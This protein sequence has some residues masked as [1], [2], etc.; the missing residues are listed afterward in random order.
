VTVKVLPQYASN[1]MIDPAMFAKRSI[2]GE[3]MDLLEWAIPPD[4]H[5]LPS[6][7]GLPPWLDTLKMV[8]QDWT[9]AIKSEGFKVVARLLSICVSLGMCQA[10]GFRAEIAGIQLFAVTALP[11]QVTSIDLINAVLDTVV[12]FCE[13]GYQCIQQQSFRPLLG[14]MDLEEFDKNYLLCMQYISFAK[15]GNLLKHASMSDNDFDKLLQDTIALGNMLCKTKGSF[16]RGLLDRKLS[17]LNV[18]AS[19]LKQIR[20]SGGLREAPYCVGLHGGSGV[21]KTTMYPSVMTTLLDGNGFASTYDRIVT[22]N[23]SDKYMSS[24]RSDTLGILIDDV[25]NTVPRFAKEAPTQKIIEFMSNQRTYANM[26]EA[27]QKGKIAVE[28]KIVLITTNKKDLNAPAYSNEPAS[29]ARR[30]NIMVTV[31]VLPQYAS[32]NMIDPAKL[33]AAFPQGLPDPPNIWQLT[34]EQAYP[35]QTPSGPASIGYK[36]INWQGKDLKDISYPEA[37]HFLLQDSRKWFTNQRA[38]VAR[39]YTAP[40]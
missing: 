18:W 7:S 26:A 19:E 13:G 23:E 28:P 39:S 3:L 9:L 37:M 6:G 36:T 27:D 17:S 25:G 30:I 32:N 38:L 35:V 16:V 20:I 10:A 33:T 11:H 8:Q 31:K 1:N 24:F 34:L 2:T 21:G 12:L 4:P 5:A 22:V 15:C 40:G 29:V 14:G